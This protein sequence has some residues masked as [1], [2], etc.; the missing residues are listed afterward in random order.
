MAGD[1]KLKYPAASTSL[2]VTN[3][4]SL[5][6]S[7]S[8]VAG[9]TSNSVANTSNVYADYEYGFT[10]T[11][12]ASNRQ[13][14][15]TIAVYVISSLNDTPTWPATSSGTIGTEGALVFADTYRRDSLCRLLWSVVADATASA[16]YTMPQMGIAQLF[17]GVC[18]THHAIFV[19]QN[20]ATSTNAGLASS[21][22]AIY[23][24]PSD[25]QYT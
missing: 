14:P 7:Q 10:F 1:I 18:P 4:H 13:S 20:L 21:G 9:W 2:T 8:L 24:T 16:I 3:L 5:A 6:A 12:H 11:S 15:S 19:T 22:S 17:G 23:Y 25:F